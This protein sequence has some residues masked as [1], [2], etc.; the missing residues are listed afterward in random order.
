MFV[1]ANLNS[2]APTLIAQ[3]IYDQ[4]Q[5]QPMKTFKYDDTYI[6]MDGI[7]SLL[8][9]LTV[10]GIAFKLIRLAGGRSDFATEKGIRRQKLKARVTLLIRALL[11]VLVLGWP[12]W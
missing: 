4:M 6:L 2:T 11:L 9:V 12:F 1:L 10:I 8:V 7:G 5:G 3:N